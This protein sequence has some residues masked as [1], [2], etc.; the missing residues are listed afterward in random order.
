LTYDLVDFFFDAKNII[1]SK[2][3]LKEL[4]ND[5]GNAHAHKP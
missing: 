4:S 3:V 5:N 1:G 2:T